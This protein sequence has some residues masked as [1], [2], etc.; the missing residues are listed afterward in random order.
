M[1]HG[2]G[3]SAAAFD[4]VCAGLEDIRTCCRIDFP[5]F[6][7]SEDLSEPWGLE[8]YADLVGHWV[9][10]VIDV[11]TDKVDVLVHSFGN[12]VLLR[13]L[14]RG[15]W[16]VRIGKVIVT[17][18]AGLK[19]RRSLK[20]RAVIG[21]VRV[22]KSPSRVLPG[23][24]ADLYLERLRSTAFWKGLGSADYAKLSG[25]MRATF[26]KVVNDHLDGLLGDA[27]RE[28]LLVWGEH[29][30]ATPVW[31]G[32]KLEE[33][34]PGSALIVLEGAGHYAFLEQPGRFV[35]IARSYLSSGEGK[36]TG[37]DSAP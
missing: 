37:G 7:R 30:T 23:T 10:R 36:P 29:D 17:G 27:A 21:L 15:G 5:G 22:L 31:M 3:S 26:S 9:D 25:P 34:M 2:W 35:A 11:E 24:L 6:G 16:N 8:D 4:G 1:L 28:M 13:M 12:R 32:R 20:T 19:P 14:A 18:G 33:R